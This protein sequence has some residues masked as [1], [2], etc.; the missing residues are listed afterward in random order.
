MASLPPPIPFSTKRGE[1]FCNLAFVI[2]VRVNVMP[3]MA[4]VAFF[5]SHDT[6]RYSN[7]CERGTEQSRRRKRKDEEEQEKDEQKYEEGAEK[8]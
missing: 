7:R 3:S 6:R 2:L 1:R 8:E 5:L 4:V